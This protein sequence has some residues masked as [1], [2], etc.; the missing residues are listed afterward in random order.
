MTVKII[1]CTQPAEL[2]RHYDG[3][4]K[5]QPCYIEL[6]LRHSTMLATWNAEVGNAVPAAV[7]NSFELRYPIPVL[8]AE[9]ANRVMKEMVPLANRILADYE[10]RWTG[11]N[12]VT[13]FGTD[14]LAAEEE[15]EALLGLDERTRTSEPNQGFDD[16]DLVAI[17]P[18]DGAVNG[19]EVS[20]YDITAETTDE[21]FDEIEAEIIS[22]LVGVNESD[23]AVVHGLDAYLREKRDELI[24]DKENETA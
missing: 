24:A 7:R 4:T 11:S 17:W 13:R 21:R 5:P 16:S 23:V 3:Q 6:D 19:C 15:I 2:F 9:A 10:E 12:T 1:E 8:T 22:D 18:V 14:A 20:E